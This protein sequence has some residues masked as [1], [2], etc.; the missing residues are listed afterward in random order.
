M[1]S[2][3][4]LSPSYHQTSSSGNSS[5]LMIPFERFQVVTHPHPAI[6]E[7]TSLNFPL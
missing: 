4:D 2:I 5:Y 6:I 7:A 1:V 3:F